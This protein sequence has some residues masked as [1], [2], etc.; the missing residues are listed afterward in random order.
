MSNKTSFDSEQAKEFLEQ[1][2]A[3]DQI[4]KED[5]EAVLSSWERLQD[6]WDDEQRDDFEVIFSQGFANALQGTADTSP[7]IIAQL[8]E[9][10]AIAQKLAQ[11]AFGSNPSQGRS[12]TGAS[13]ASRATGA[14]SKAVSAVST[15]STILTGAAPTPVASN[16]LLQERFDAQPS[17]IRSIDNKE[18]LEA[19]VE[20]DADR[21]RERARK[22]EQDAE[23]ARRSSDSTPSSS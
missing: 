16:A 1:L 4:M 10:L 13:F 11:L 5:L 22:K 14:V 3:F 7:Q 6:A 12:S 2:E 20:L 19:Y 9:Q 17:L 8:G 15:A 18:Q 23:N 21:V